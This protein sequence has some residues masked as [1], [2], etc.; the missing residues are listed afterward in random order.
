MANSGNI[1]KLPGN[2]DQVADF[3]TENTGDGKR[4]GK[5]SSFRTQCWDTGIREKKIKDMPL[6]HTALHRIKSFLIEVF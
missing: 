6:S 2:M 5:V 1:N 4:L 3:N